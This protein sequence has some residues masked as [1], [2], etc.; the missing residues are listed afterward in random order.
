MI[1][2]HCHPLPFVDDGAADWDA[3]LQMARA[4]SADGITQWV[5]T[6]HWTGKAGEAEKV[7]AVREELVARLEEARIPLRVHPGNE[8]VLVPNLAQAL[9]EGTALTLGGSSYIL[10]ETA[11]FETGAYIHSALFQL[12]SQGY[13]VILAHPERLRSWQESLHD[14]RELVYRG[15]YLQVNAGSLLGSFGR[16]AQRTAES[17]L[18][19]GWVSFL[20]TDAHSP[21]H[22]PPLLRA[23]V[24]RASQIA[25]REA[26]LDMVEANPARVLCGDYVPAITPEMI[27][28]SRFSWIPWLRQ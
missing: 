20:A 17:L 21:D 8:V 13:R 2:L 1:D 16:A 5:A 7:R 10:L 25:G 11:Q 24:E 6:P 22:R 26:V 4:A 12:Q 18:K 28:R 14:L 27:P 15:C 19:Q 3:A 23:A 9:Q